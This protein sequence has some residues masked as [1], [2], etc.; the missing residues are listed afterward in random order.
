MPS[1][2]RELR[3][4]PAVQ[5]I[6]ANLG[7]LVLDKGLR[8]VVGLFVGTWVA[9]YL[10]PADFGVLSF[11]LATATLLAVFSGL[12][13][14]L[15][16]RRDLVPIDAPTNTILGTVAF[17]R[18]AVAALL[19]LGLVV[20][21][22]GLV[23]EGPLRPTLLW[24]GLLLFQPAV[25]TV[26]LWFQARQLSKRTVIA[27]NTAF[28][29][30]SAARVG[31]VLADASLPAFAALIALDLALFTGLLLRA[32]ATAGCPPSA[33]RVEAGL[34]RGLL[35]RSWPLLLSGLAI[36]VYLKTDQI[37][38]NLLAGP[39]VSGHYA[40]AVKI[41]EICYLGPVILASSLFPT[42][43]RS[44]SGQAPEAYD[45]RIRQYLNLS[46]ALA[47]AVT[48]PL[49]LLAPGIIRLLYGEAFA[50][51]APVLMVHVFSLVFV[52]QG[53]AR[54][55]WLLGENFTRFS[56]ASTS[57][58]AVLNVALNFWLIP[59]FGGIG[60]A[61]ATLVSLASSDV[62]SSLVWSRTRTL[63]GWQLRAL[64]GAWKLPSPATP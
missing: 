36:I 55:E 49:A 45:R 13:L 40:A 50:P 17:L 37:M 34:A 7:W 16:V 8:L 58:G 25:L 57:A 54:Q 52:A 63:G 10:G 33:W 21:A 15:L 31:L 1:F 6:A 20:A 48:L 47:Y 4:R 42:I 32:A 29:L 53:V 35:R 30:S 38:L 64:I 19:Y 11:A 51:A 44:R 39:T 9:R 56:L 12:G 61:I 60:S 2:L 27:Q 62:F 23:R 43:V 14:D 46:A 5:A 3:S 28:L 41:S 59:R 24:S 26:D 18:T 22:L